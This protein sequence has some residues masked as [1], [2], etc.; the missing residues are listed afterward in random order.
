MSLI[1]FNYLYIK[2][3]EK[4][5]LDQKIGKNGNTSANKNKH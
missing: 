1:K 5:L 3:Y 4:K 2:F